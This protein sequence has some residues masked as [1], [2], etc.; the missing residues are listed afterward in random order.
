MGAVHRHIE[1]VCGAVAPIFR[2]IL[3]ADSTA[4]TTDVIYVDCPTL[5]RPKTVF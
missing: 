4:N 5:D 2:S 1:D 3:T